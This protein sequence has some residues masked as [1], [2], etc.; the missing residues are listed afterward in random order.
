[1]TTIKA[2]VQNGRIDIP[3][4]AEL[5]EGDEVDVQIQ[6][7]DESVFLGKFQQ[8]D[9]PESIAAWID[10]FRKLEP[11]IFTEEELA[12]QREYEK[13]QKEWEKAT[14]FERADKVTKGWQ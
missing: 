4:P 14:F 10:A 8:D 6:S 11:L 3:A 7:V 5:R 1:M 2:I 13:R 9:S 12:E